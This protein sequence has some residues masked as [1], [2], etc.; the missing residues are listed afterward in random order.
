[1]TF[2]TSCSH[3]EAHDSGVS[4]EQS[5]TTPNWYPRDFSWDKYGAEYV[6]LNSPLENARRCSAASATWREVGD[7]PARCANSEIVSEL[8]F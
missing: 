2:T 8:A 5:V 7:P 6:L 3:D 1:M 4:A